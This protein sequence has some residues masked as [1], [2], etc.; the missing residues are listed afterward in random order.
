MYHVYIMYNINAVYGSN[1]L[2]LSSSSCLVFILCGDPDDIVSVKNGTNV[3]KDIV[4][5]LIDLYKW[6]VSLC[7]VYGGILLIT[8]L[9]SLH[10]T[11]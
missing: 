9:L 6:V 2:N 4:F 3:N 10:I 5:I 11:M 8:H 1:L 7:M